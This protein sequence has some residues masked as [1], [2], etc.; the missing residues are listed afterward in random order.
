MSAESSLRLHLIE[1]CGHA[2]D[3]VDSVLNGERFEP[4]QQQADQSA[5]PIIMKHA[6]IFLE[7]AGHA[8]VSFLGPEPYRFNWCGQEGQECEKTLVYEAMAAQDK[9]A[10]AFAGRLLDDDH[11]CVSIQES[12]P[13]Q[14]GWCGRASSCV[15]KTQP[16]QERKLRL[17]NNYQR[18]SLPRRCKTQKN[19]SQM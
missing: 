13:A 18:S 6:A 10:M 4:S 16:R 5:V 17:R 14:V 12:F 8:C 1:E 11:T 15:E 3:E 2:R 9:A 7:V 19:Y